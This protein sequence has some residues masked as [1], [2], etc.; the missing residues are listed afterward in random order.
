MGP[1]EFVCPEAGKVIRMPEGYCAFVPAPLAAVAYDADLALLLSRADAA[2]SELSGLGRL[3]EYPQKGFVFDDERLKNPPGP[4]APDYFDELLER[5][6]DIC[7][8]EKTFWR[9]VPGFRRGLA[10]VIVRAA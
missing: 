10:F 6:R 3:S 8:A 1:N 5:I 9:G 2:V 4:G 7:S